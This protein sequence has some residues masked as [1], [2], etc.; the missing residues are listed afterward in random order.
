MSQL[1]RIVRSKVIACVV[2]SLICCM[3]LGFPER[4]QFV[5]P[6]HPQTSKTEDSVR[7]AGRDHHQV[8]QIQQVRAQK[9]LQWRSAQSRKFHF[10]PHARIRPHG[11][12]GLYLRT[13]HTNNVQRDVILRV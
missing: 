7:E 11:R 12:T 6:S 4:V 1:V 5:R 2:K 9:V 8:V 10:L 3:V 13:I